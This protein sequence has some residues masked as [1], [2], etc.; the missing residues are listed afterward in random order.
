ME[1]HMMER[2]FTWAIRYKMHTLYY[3][4]IFPEAPILESYFN[5]KKSARFRR[6]SDIPDDELGK[7]FPLRISEKRSYTADGKSIEL[8]GYFKKIT[9]TRPEEQLVYEYSA[10]KMNIQ[11]I[12]GC[13]SAGI[14][15]AVT[16]DEVVGR[17]MLPLYKRLEKSYHILFSR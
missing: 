11:E 14:P 17:I 6:L 9:I 16:R 13:V 8:P 12:A 1:P 15:G 5:I 2:H 10:G 7:W 4:R 3:L